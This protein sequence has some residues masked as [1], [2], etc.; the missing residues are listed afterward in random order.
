MADV[1]TSTS[2]EQNGIYMEEKV[3]LDAQPTSAGSSAP[4]N[5]QTPQL[6]LATKNTDTN[7]NSKLEGGVKPDETDAN[8]QTQQSDPQQQSP[9][10]P[11]EGEE[12]NKALV[13][14]VEYLF[15]REYLSSDYNIVS[16]MN[17]ELYVPVSLI[18]EQPYLKALTQNVELILNAMRETDKVVLD[19]A[20][21]LVKPSFKLQRNT[22]ILRDIPENTTAEDIKVLFSDDEKL[23]DQITDVRK[24]VANTWFV[25]LMSEDITTDAFLHVR[26]K[27]IN[28]LAVQARVKSENLLKSTYVPSSGYYGSGYPYQQQH[29]QQYNNLGTNGYDSRGYNWN[30]NSMGTHGSRGYQSSFRGGYKQMDYNHERGFDKKS[31]GRFNQRRGQRKDFAPRGGK[32]V[33]NAANANTYTAPTNSNNHYNS[34]TADS[35]RGGRP[36]GRRNANPQQITS[37]TNHIAQSTT[38]TLSNTTNNQS[39]NSNISSTSPANSTTAGA[40]NSA[41]TTHRKN[42]RT[43]STS[44]SVPTLGLSHFPPLGRSV[45]TGYQKPDVKRYTKDQI[46][47][48]IGSITDVQKPEF[49]T[50]DLSAI[51]NVANY[52]LE[53]TKE[54]SPSARMEL[55][56]GTKIERKRGRSSSRGSD[57]GSRPHTTAAAVVASSV[58]AQQKKLEEAKAAA[59]KSIAAPPKKPVQPPANDKAPNKEAKKDQQAEDT[60]LQSSAKIDDKSGKPE[61]R[62]NEGKPVQSATTELK[63]ALSPSYADIARTGSPSPAEKKEVE[64]PKQDANISSNAT[65]NAVATTPAAS[66]GAKQQLRPQGAAITNGA[67]QQQSLSITKA[68][69]Q[70]ESAS[71]Q[72]PS[73]PKK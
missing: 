34:N 31:G 46:A 26:Q 2:I 53:S 47:S 9:F 65:D 27:K 63:S 60:N 45:G 36:G 21:M 18:T 49:S 40:N 67:L 25:T 35:K 62:G 56:E 55:F 32:Y 64:V 72:P 51:S 29:Y 54:V 7:E 23:A 73:S 69:P 41:N 24:D 8:Q 48:V 38:G 28:G 39:S 57:K 13:Q 37:N 6:N 43:K 42:E 1:Q 59:K 30:R 52:E 4:S 58:H 19:E 15:S 50:S 20:N 14:Q 3:E 16:Q 33:P 11:L 44:S 66:T 10:Q 68:T 17:S 5:E 22:I 71:S 70:G 61:E 12:L